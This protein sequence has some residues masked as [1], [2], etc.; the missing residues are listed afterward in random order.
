MKKTMLYPLAGLL[1]AA[2]SPAPQDAPSGDPI[3]IN[4]VGYYVNQSKTAVIEEEGFCDNYQL[5]E[6]ATSQIVWEGACSRVSKSP[7][8]DK[9]HHI[10]DF[11]SVKKPGQYRLIAGDYTKDI[12][13][14]EHPY[15]DLAKA[16]MKA[17]FYQRSGEP[18]LELY[19]GQWARPLGHPDTCVLVHPS[20]AIKGRPEGTVLSCPGG[21]YDAGDFNKYIVN[22]GFSIGEMLTIYQYNPKYFNALNLN[23]P[24]SSNA[25]PDVLDEI[26][27]Q[28]KWMLTMQDPTDGGVYHKLTSPEFGAF[29]MPSECHQPRY[30]V[31]KSTAAALDFAATMA[32]ASRI[33][34]E[35]DEHKAFAHQAIEAATKAWQWARRNPKKAYIQNELNQKFDPDITTGEYGDREFL[36]EFFWA[37]T[38]LYFTTSKRIYLNEAGS[39]L[40]KDYRLPTWGQVSGLAAMEWMVFTTYGFSPETDRFGNKYTNLLTSYCDKLLEEME[41]SIYDTPYGNQPHDFGWGCLAE[42]CCGKGISLLFAY[43]MT[44]E[45][46][47]LEAAFKCADYLLGRNAT[48]YCYVTGFGS[49]SPMYPHHR[50]SAFD[51]IDAPIPGLLV[52]G[53]N[54]AQQDQVEGYPSKHP[55]ESYIDV[56]DSYSSNEVAIN[57]N[58]ALFSFI[59]WLDAEVK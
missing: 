29:Q 21:W 19:A 59:G 38:E 33:Y 11:S 5:Q 13:I 35:Y 26:L 20:A 47:Y 12:L 27:V 28:L 50:I 58:A 25:T 14:A 56:T 53:P 34:R 57:W 4:Q 1:L 52:G 43:K 18:L 23:I 46:K 42:S 40:A 36:D 30:V 32:L 39:R 6:I 48:G 49:K 51:S 41:Q 22:S 8:S 31:Q 17:F 45:R 2:C 16:A 54:P 37:S 3:R 7:W 10:I 24:E 9:E 15:R 55:D 44:N